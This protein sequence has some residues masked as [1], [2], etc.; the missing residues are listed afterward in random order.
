MIIEK[1][2]EWWKLCDPFGVAY[3]IVSLWK[4]GGWSPFG[5]TLASQTEIYVHIYRRVIW[6]YCMTSWLFCLILGKISHVN[7][8][9]SCGWVWHMIHIYRGEEHLWDNSTNMMMWNVIS[10]GLFKKRSW[11]LCFLPILVK[12]HSLWEHICVGFQTDSINSYTLWQSNIAGNG[13]PPRQE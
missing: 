7:Q 8:Q 9:P 12:I 3:D 5:D 11:M 13:Q 2:G 4:I 10:L 1:P 6:E